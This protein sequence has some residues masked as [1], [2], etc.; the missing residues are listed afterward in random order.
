MRLSSFPHGFAARSR[1]LLWLTLLDIIGELA[2]RLSVPPALS[3]NTHMFF[4]YPPLG[5]FHDAFNLILSRKLTVAGSYTRL[6][7]VT[8]VTG[9]GLTRAVIQLSI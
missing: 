1:I 5:G 9:A 3:N 6:S 4:Y 7:K 8:F 2:R